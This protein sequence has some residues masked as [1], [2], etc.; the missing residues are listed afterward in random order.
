MSR[1][2]DAPHNASSACSDIEN[3]GCTSKH[4]RQTLPVCLKLAFCS[5]FAAGDRCAAY[6]HDQSVSYVYILSFIL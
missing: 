4:A 5:I 1:Q 2:F 6:V 3:N